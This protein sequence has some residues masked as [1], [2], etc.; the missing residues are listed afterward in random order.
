[1]ERGSQDLRPDGDGYDELRYAFAAA[2]I[3][4][5]IGFGL[6]SQAHPVRAD[7][8]RAP[9]LQPGSKAGCGPS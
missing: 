6:W 9:V 4:S 3:W 5:A 7:P 1:M 8:P 2:L